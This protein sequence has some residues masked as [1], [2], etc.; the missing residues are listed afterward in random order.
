MDQVS[1][2]GSSVYVR[3]QGPYH[4][5]QSDAMG[6]VTWEQT[7]TLHDAF[8]EL[9]YRITYT[10]PYTLSEHPQEIPAVFPGWGL[11]HTYHYYAGPSPYT[12]PGTIASILLLCGGVG[13]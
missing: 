2:S 9:D 8:V 7:T 4:F 6:G 11:N 12:D 3:K 1:V 5:T 10:G 13:L